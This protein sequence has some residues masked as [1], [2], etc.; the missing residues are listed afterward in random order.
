[1][2]NTCLTSLI[3]LLLCHILQAKLDVCFIVQLLDDLLEDRIL[4]QSGKV[5]N[6][7]ADMLHYL[8]CCLY[9]TYCSLRGDTVAMLFDNIN[10][11]TIS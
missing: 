8:F 2:S 5:L 3:R 6:F 10:L 1:M 11:T 7:L 4:V 9:H